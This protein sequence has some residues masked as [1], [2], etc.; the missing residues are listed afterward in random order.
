MS[1]YDPIAGFYD[2]WSRSVVEDI[3]FYVRLAAESGGPVLELGV[4]TGRIAVPIAEAGIDIIGIDS[5]RQMLELCAA[6]AAAAGVRERL[7]LRVGELASPPRGRAVPL[8]IVPFRAYLHLDSHEARLRALQ[9]AHAV[10]EPGGLLAFDVFRPSPEDVEETHGLWLEREA[11]IWERAEWDT[12]AQELLLT[13]RGPGGETLMRLHWADAS[14]WR[15]L[16]AETGFE[17]EGEFGWFDGRPLAH[18]EDMVFVA[19]KPDG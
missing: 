3:A 5:S 4:G 19:R 15:E 12:H 2:E 11:G 17:L 14:A 6:R 13:V 16:L 9:A 1:V 7:D 8:V 10:L 18:G